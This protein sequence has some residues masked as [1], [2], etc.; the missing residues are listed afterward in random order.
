M[1]SNVAVTIAAEAR[2]PRLADLQAHRLLRKPAMFAER[3][4]LTL[5]TVPEPHSAAEMRGRHTGHNG[6]E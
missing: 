6:K 4:P 3:I 2:R 5:E 1:T